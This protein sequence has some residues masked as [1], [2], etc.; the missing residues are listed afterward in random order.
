MD[1]QWIVVMDLD[2]NGNIVDINNG[3]GLYENFTI[4]FYWI[5]IQIQCAIVGFVN[6]KGH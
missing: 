2:Y 4:F 5:S 1:I 3:C 6:F